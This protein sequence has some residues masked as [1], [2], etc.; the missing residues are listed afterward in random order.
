MLDQS[1]NRPAIILAEDEPD[2]LAI[3][4]RLVRNLVPHYEVITVGDGNAALEQ[5]KQRP[6]PLVIADYNMPGM[7][8]LQLTTLIKDT[9]PTTK[10]MLVTAY[11]TPDLQQRA[12]AQ[13]VDHYLAKPFSI[14]ELEQILL[15]VL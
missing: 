10:V 13:G 3:L 15:R 12:R 9:S 6:V 14:D 2:I 1:S 7:T 11:H 8:G 5:L 4:H